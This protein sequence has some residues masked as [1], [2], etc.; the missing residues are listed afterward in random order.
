MKM[1]LFNR[2]AITI[3]GT[4]EFLAWVKETH[5]EL[6][7]WN[8]SSLN[9]HPSTYTVDIEDQ[10][11]WGDCF[12]KY[13]EKIFKNEVGQYIYNDASWPP[14]SLELYRKWFRFEYHEYVY[15]LAEKE[16]ELHDE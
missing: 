6:H 14:V 7:R 9:H 2:S 16:L 3:Y 11:N 10:N 4:D 1:K 12:E 5:P 15:D 13:F 8:L